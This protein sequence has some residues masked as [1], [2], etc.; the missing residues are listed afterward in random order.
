MLVF[1]TPPN[2]TQRDMA[3]KAM[4]MKGVMSSRLRFRFVREAKT[5]KP[6]GARECARRRRQVGLA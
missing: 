6:N 2:P 3:L 4:H 5:Y 1:E